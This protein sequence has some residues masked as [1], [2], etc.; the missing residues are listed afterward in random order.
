MTGNTAQPHSGLRAVWT[1]HAF[2]CT[3]CRC[4]SCTFAKNPNYLQCPKT[5]KMYWSD[6]QILT[7]CLTQLKLTVLWHHGNINWFYKMSFDC[8]WLPYLSHE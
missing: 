2:D 1:L 3:F 8:C 5:V 7:K 6:V 4:C